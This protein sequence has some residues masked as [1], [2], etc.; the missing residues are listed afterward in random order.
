VKLSNAKMR[1][2]LARRPR[3]V[4]LAIIVAIILLLWD[5]CKII[6]SIFAGLFFII[7]LF[8]TAFASN[9]LNRI[10]WV[11]GFFWVAAVLLP[12][13]VAFA[14]G[15]SNSVRFVRIYTEHGV[16]HRIVEAATA[17]GLVEN[18]DYVVRP[19]PS[20]SLLSPRWGVVFIVPSRK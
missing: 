12:V 5:P 17:Q 20:P 11:A 8:A 6:A 7:G 18:R 1:E 14:R 4:E 10:F 2:M 9:R 15:D 13:D 19:C 3:L 16:R